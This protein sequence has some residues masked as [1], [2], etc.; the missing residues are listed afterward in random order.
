MSDK[1]ILAADGRPVR[2]QAP[3]P[4]QVIFGGGPAAIHLFNALGDRAAL[5]TRELERNSKDQGALLTV[6]SCVVGL[7]GGELVV[8]PELLEDL[9]A[10]EAQIGLAKQ[11]DGGWHVF[12]AKPT[13]A[14]LNSETDAPL[15]L[16]PR[17]FAC[18]A[19]ARRYKNAREAKAS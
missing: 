12:L 18:G 9:R 13:G 15:D 11:E 4:H 14:E 6:L 8:T 1:A 17:Q 2:P 5:L 10:S 7:A 19:A 3:D 16:S